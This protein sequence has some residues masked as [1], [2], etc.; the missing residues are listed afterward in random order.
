MLFRLLG[1]IGLPEVVESGNIDEK[2]MLSLWEGLCA[3]A[4]GPRSGFSRLGGRYLWYSLFSL[5]FERPEERGCRG[6]SATASG[7]TLLA[8]GRRAAR[9]SLRPRVALQSSSLSFLG[10][11]SM[12]GGGPRFR[13][14]EEC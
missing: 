13:A 2:L 8:T 11:R 1:V 3:E 4:L 14:G 7:R 6:G 12:T 10:L 9:V 5:R